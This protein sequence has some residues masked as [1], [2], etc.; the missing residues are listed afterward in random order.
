MSEQTIVNYSG[1]AP[2][3]DSNFYDLFDTTVACTGKRQLQMAGLNRIVLHIN[4]AGAGSA[5][6]IVH[7]DRSDD[8]GA[9][10]V[11]DAQTAIQANEADTPHDI[12]LVF[13]P[14]DDFRVRWEND[15]GAAQT[16]WQ[17]LI[18]LAGE[19]SPTS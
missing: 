11:T 9:T 7:I 10:W 16:T 13:E 5:D 17:V 19:R 1:T 14:Y 4:H 2:G 8:R 15:G 3:A 6:G 12:D 18:T